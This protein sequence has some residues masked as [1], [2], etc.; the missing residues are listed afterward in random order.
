MLSRVRNFEERRAFGENIQIKEE[1][2]ETKGGAAPSKT[3]FF[4]R[5][6]YKVFFKLE[7][8]N[9]HSKH[10]DYNQLPQMRPVNN[11][12]PSLQPMRNGEMPSTG[13][14]VRNCAKEIGPYKDEVSDLTL[15]FSVLVTISTTYW[16][17]PAT[18]TKNDL[19]LIWDKFYN[20]HY[21][22]LKGESDFIH[23]AQDKEGL[24]R[25]LGNGMRYRFG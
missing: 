22:Q 16:G 19:L 17:K 12:P 9:V 15:F 11:K 25:D 8:F 5:K 10:C 14:P 24:Y 7:E 1:P 4:C 23:C 13:R 21:G 20:F 2:G 3:A 6:C 18:K